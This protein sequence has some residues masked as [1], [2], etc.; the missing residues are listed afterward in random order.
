ME[1]FRASKGHIQAAPDGLRDGR[2]RTV[3]RKEHPMTDPIKTRA[4]GS[5]DTAHYIRRGRMARSQAAHDMARS[6]LPRRTSRI[7]TGRPWVLPTAIVSIAVLALPY[8]V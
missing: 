2:Y 5:I 4:D 3:H 8:M 7:G 1:T 6:L